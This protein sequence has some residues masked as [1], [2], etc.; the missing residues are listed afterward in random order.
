MRNAAV[1]W[2]RRNAVALVALFV[3]LG[4]TAYAASA[5]DGKLIENGTITGKKLKKDTIGGKQVKESG[6]GTVPSATHADSAGTA[7]TAKSAATA[8]SADTADTAG[9]STSAKVAQSAQ[10][11]ATLGAFGPEAFARATQIETSGPFETDPNAGGD[12]DFFYFPEIDFAI[13][14]PRAPNKPGINGL[15]QLRHSDLTKR[16]MLHIRTP[17]FEETS[18]YYSEGINWPVNNNGTEENKDF[19]EMTAISLETDFA[20]HVECVADDSV[21]DMPVT[22]VAIKSMP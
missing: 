1:T 21:A 20:V 12:H 14:T 10:T 7:E 13:R 4:G 2:A 8:G 5:I 22:C 3:A 6:L 9:S 15:V 18:E 17:T 11:S 16:M 19:L